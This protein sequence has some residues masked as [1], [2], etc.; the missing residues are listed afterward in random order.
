MASLLAPLRKSELTITNTKEFVK[1]IQ[2][3][4]VPDRY[5]MVSFDEASL[6][7]KAPLEESIENILK[8]IYVNKEITTDIPKQEM[9][10]LLILCTL[11]VDFTFNN[12]TYI[13]VDGVAMGLPL[14][15]VLTNILM[16]ELETSV[17]PNLS[18]KVKLWKRFVEDTY[19]LARSEYIDNI[20]L[21]PNS[22]H[23][24][25]KFTIE[26]EKDNTIPFLDIL[27]VI[28]PG[29]IETTV[30]RKKT[31]TD[32]YLNWYSFAPKSW[33][34][35]TL[36]NLVRRSHIN[37]STEKHLKEEPNILERHSMKLISIRIGQLQSFQGN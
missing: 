11:N 10:E 36:K 29:K 16:V 33:K 26:I 28:K 2:K 17:I 4:K 6:F 9:K 34:W 3:Q 14:G 25:I 19:C 37:C 22:S 20:L 24:N 1:Y 7:T 31:Y 35:G 5:E 21:A 32:L 15:P 27:M 12:E 18:N 13:E 30:D 23:K 8:K